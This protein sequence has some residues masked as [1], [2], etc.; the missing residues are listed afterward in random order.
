MATLP[1]CLDRPT[2]PGH[3]ERW[4]TLW[5]YRTTLE[6]T[7]LLTPSWVAPFQDGVVV[8]DGNTPRVTAFGADGKVRWI[9][10]PPRGDGPGEMRYAV[11]ATETDD[12]LWVLASP[13]RL[14]LLSDRGSVIRQVSIVPVPTGWVAGLE[15]SGEQEALLV[16]GKRLA[17]VSLSDGSIVGDARP[18]PWTQEPPAD[19]IGDLRLA[20]HKDVV[21]VG[22]RYG[23]EVLILNGD[24]LRGA[25]LRPEIT[26]RVRGRRVD[27]GNMYI[28][29]EPSGQ[30]PFGA[31]SMS[32]TGTELWVVTGGAWL[33]DR[34]GV[35]EQRLNDRLLVYS[36]DGDLIGERT[37]P[38]D[39]EDIAVSNGTVYLLSA[40]LDP[41]H[42]YVL[43]AL[44]R[45]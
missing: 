3:T 8:G 1:G 34:V 39:T 12:G 5:S 43:M 42:D 33:N 7:V 30:I 9:Y 26:Y 11:D 20:V 28:F 44:R 38:F 17:R 10:A 16:V 4:D 24:S 29:L 40:L 15:T 32:L 18:L 2:A 41:D 6:D 35:E 23:P 21:A 14:I 22:M 37:L 25:I 31:W 13:P 19:W 27:S 36:L 45:R